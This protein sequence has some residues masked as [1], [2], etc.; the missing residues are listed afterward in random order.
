V[1]DVKDLKQEDRAP[2]LKFEQPCQV[3]TC[4]RCV[5]WIAYFYLL[6]NARL[7]SQTSK[8]YM[9]IIIESWLTLIHMIG[10]RPSTQFKIASLSQ[11]VLLMHQHTTNC[12]N[13]MQVPLDHTIFGIRVWTPF[14]GDASGPFSRCPDRIAETRLW[15]AGETGNSWK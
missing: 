14:N 8:S 5:I 15:N 12:S 13:I 3:Q 9:I 6:H 1:N 7:L 2:N 11:V 4:K 10:K